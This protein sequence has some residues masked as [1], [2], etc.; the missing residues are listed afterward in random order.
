MD[1]TRKNTM[2]IVFGTSTKIPAHLDVLRFVGQTL[3]VSASHVHSIYKDENDQMFYIKFSDEA[4]FNR[5]ASEMDEQYI[6][7]FGDGSRSPV[8]LDVASSLFRYVRIFNLPPE[9]DDKEISTVLSQF[10]SIRQHVREKYPMDY[11]F[12]VYSGIRG[13]HMEISKELPANLF[14][15]HFKARL[16]YE[17]LKN[18][19]FYCKGEGHVKA[20]CPKLAGY[21]ELQNGGQYSQVLANAA[22]QANAKVTTHALN[23]TV[24]PLIAK[25]KKDTTL[26]KNDTSKSSDQPNTSDES[27]TVDELSSNND[28][29]EICNS[30]QKK[31]I[32][33]T[34][35]DN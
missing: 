16:Y 1:K 10:G 27:S 33:R 5:F 25:N 22:I 23:M 21:K 15:G 17:G 35:I 2:K 13:V 9:I 3:S 19:C 12:S 30:E 6:F 31:A 7:Q 34:T 26:I 20:I 29:M 11:G 28:T 18:K 32:K 24:L 4:A 14:I 8:R